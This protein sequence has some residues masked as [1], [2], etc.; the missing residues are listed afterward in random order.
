MNLV[1]ADDLLEH[2]AVLL[3]VGKK[4]STPACRRHCVVKAYNSVSG[5]PAERLSKAFA[6]CTTKFPDASDPD[7]KKHSKEKPDSMK[8]KDKAFDALLAKV[9][10][11]KK[12]KRKRK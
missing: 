9:K 3:E 1:Q 4:R 5:R 8:R 11:A 2:L 6:V 7:C 10:K 12:A